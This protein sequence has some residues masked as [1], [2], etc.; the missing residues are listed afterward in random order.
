MSRVFINAESIRSHLGTPNVNQ[1]ALAEYIE[2]IQEREDISSIQIY[3]R[4]E[5]DSIDK[6]SYLSGARWL[7]AFCRAPLIK[8]SC[9]VGKYGINNPGM[10]RGF[11]S[12][13]AIDIVI[14]NRIKFSPQQ[15]ILL[16]TG[17][18]DLW[19]VYQDLAHENTS[20][21]F[22]MLSPISESYS[23]FI[24]SEEEIEDIHNLKVHDIEEVIERR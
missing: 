24:P 12:T 8:Y 6:L 14:S 20:K 2:L 21:M 19:P 16:I 4:F 3:S 22:H 9:R 10:R 13:H 15:D 1:E 18:Y 7:S 11:N 5:G 17:N 23:E